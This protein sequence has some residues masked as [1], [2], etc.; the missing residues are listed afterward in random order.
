MTALSVRAA[1]KPGELDATTL[2]TTTNVQGSHF[3][4]HVRDV[5][6]ENVSSCPDPWILCTIVLDSS[7][8]RHDSGT[9]SSRDIRQGE[10]LNGP[11]AP[12]SSASAAADVCSPAYKEMTATHPLYGKHSRPPLTPEAWWT[13]L[14]NK[15]MVH[16]G[17]TEQGELAE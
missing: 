17:A 6:D 2:C 9:R 5:G 15:C 11:F 1:F 12:I 3:P 13:A 14:I 4:G 10:T 16:A 7:H 8:V